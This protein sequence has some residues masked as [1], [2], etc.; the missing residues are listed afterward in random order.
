[1]MIKNHWYIVL[2]LILTV[3]CS[4]EEVLPSELVKWVDNPENGL[5]QEKSLGDVSF[6]ALYKPHDYMVVNEFKSDVI[7]Q[8]DLDQ[9]KEELKG[10]QHYNFRIKSNMGGDV[11]MNGIEDQ[12]E[13]FNRVGY[14]SFDAQYDF[15][16][17]E[18]QDTLPCVLFNFVRTHGVAPY[19]DFA[20][21]FDANGE[22]IKNK[23]L[24]LKDRVFTHD[25]IKFDF[26]KEDIEEVPTLI[27][28]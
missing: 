10:L 24:L 18:D 22:E 3:G 20:L 2:L 25:Y 6:I 11:V 7:E 8:A 17:V 12:Q 5:K 19:V 16:L 14:Y 26:S 15:Q 21:A 1:M 4:K 9:R 13:Y 27:T 28:K 23:Q